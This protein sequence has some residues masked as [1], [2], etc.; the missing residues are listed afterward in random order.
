MASRLP[1]LRPGR[2]RRGRRLAL[3]AGATAA[4]AAYRNR[5]LAANE[6]RYAEQLGLTAT[7]PAEGPRPPHP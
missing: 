4:I 5:T 1:F 2:R 6:R 7:H 3:L